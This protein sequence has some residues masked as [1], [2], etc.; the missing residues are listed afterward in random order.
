MLK[1]YGYF[2]S[3][4][5]YRVR[6]AL[7]LKEIPYELIPIHLTKDGGHQFTD[8]YTKLNPQQL[9]PTLIDGDLSLT[10]SMAIIEYLEEAYP[11]IPLLP[12]DMAGKARVRALSQIVACEVHPLN[13]LRI[14]KYLVEDMGLSEDQRQTWMENWIAKG[15][16]AYETFLTTSAET[17]KF[18]HGDTPTMADICLIPQIFN[19][20]RIDQDLSPYPTILRIEEACQALPAFDKA[21]P[22]NQ[23]DA[24]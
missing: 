7:N 11:D 13:N 21:Q 20:R 5:A 15:F 19:A 3:S 1:L 2:Q 16:A 9:V 24:A 4:A 22:K 12:S 17:G 18:S 23:P 6:I 14:R 10:Q 8:D